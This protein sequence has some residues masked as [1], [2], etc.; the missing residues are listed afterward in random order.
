MAGRIARIIVGVTVAEPTNPRAIPVFEPAEGQRFQAE[1]AAIGSPH[2]FQRDDPVYVVRG[3]QREQINAF[4]TARM[5]DA[6]QP[7]GPKTL[8]IAVPADGW[9][10]Q[11]GGNPP[12]PFQGVVVDFGVDEQQVTFDVVS[13]RVAELILSG[14]GSGDVIIF[15]DQIQ[16]FSVD[17]KTGK[18][19]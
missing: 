8:R 5:N 2:G 12:I 3:G 15:G 4:L 9:Q 11:I 6:I 16:R 1:L 7:G 18:V 19:T 14:F 17:P 10:I 13:Q